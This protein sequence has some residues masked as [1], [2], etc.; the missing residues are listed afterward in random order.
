MGAALNSTEPQFLYPTSRKFPF[1]EA[2]EQIV[3]ELERRNWQVSDIT[4]EFHDYGSGAQKFRA[5]SSIKSRDFKLWFGR[6]QRLMPGGH[7]NDTAAI[8]EIV[9]PKKIIRVHEDES[10]PTF[11]LYVSN[12]WER[13]REK[14]MNGSKVNSKLYKEPRM[15]LKYQGKCFCPGAERDVTFSSSLLIDSMLGKSVENN[16]FKGV[17]HN[18]TGRR[19]PFLVHDNDL[20]REYEP[21]PRR[22]SWRK[23]RH[24]PANPVFFRTEEVFQEFRQYL[25]QV[26]LAQ[27]KGSPI[28]R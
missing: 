11:Y 15:Y 24:L 19:P 13:D 28:P 9:I 14:F 3:R 8:T 17:P 18:H 25:E 6:K 12:N 10:G 27:I 16:K 20:G 23:F 21:E 7:W 4:V 22:W 2:C 5:V 1:D 26:V